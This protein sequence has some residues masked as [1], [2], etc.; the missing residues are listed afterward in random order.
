[1]V[2]LDLAAIL[3]RLQYD[4]L[5]KNDPP[6]ITFVSPALGPNGL[7]VAQIL[8]YEVSRA[9]GQVKIQG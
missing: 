2:L 6:L 7:L 3:Y 5:H 9:S 4:S 8:G 1:M